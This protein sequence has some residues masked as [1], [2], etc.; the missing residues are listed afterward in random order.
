MENIAKFTLG[1]LNRTLSA[2]ERKQF[3][4]CFIN[5]LVRFY[6]SEFAKYKTA[7]FKVTGSR[8]VSPKQTIV[9]STMKLGND[10]KKI[11]WSVFK[12]DGKVQVYD[13]I[14]DG[15]SMSNIQRA[16][17][18]GK[19]NGIQITEEDKKHIQCTDESEKG[20]RAKFKKFLPL[21]IKDYSS[22]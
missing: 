7:V 4:E 18:Q 15:V 11:N 1:V 22:L 16:D 20:V 3:L 14:I 9:Y 21:F 8:K 6:S 19:I 17:I 5:M 10:V 13:V 12:I 2:S